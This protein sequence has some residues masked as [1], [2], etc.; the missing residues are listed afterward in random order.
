[1]ILSDLAIFTEGKMQVFFIIFCHELLISSRNLGRIFANFLF[2]LISVA[3]F[4]LLA[5]GQETQGSTTFYSI[6]IIWFSL[7]SV[8]I[9]SATDFLK[10]DFEDGSI[11]QILNSCDNFEVFI[12]AKMLANWLVNSLPIIITILPIGYLI[13]L[14]SS[15]S[16]NLFL[17][18]FL[19]SLVINFICS[20]CGS[21]SILGNSAPMIA[22]IALPLIVPVILLAC[23]GFS[24]D[25]AASAKILF[26]MCF[27]IGAI[28]V[29]AAAKIVKI[30][31]D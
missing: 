26:G 4:L 12:C 20:F 11:E 14:D 1:M 7:L 2:F 19:A 16:Y 25:F 28:S 22:V 10:K 3:I 21:L 15:Q 23:G 13:N 27:F 29:F 17:L 24:A 9:F 8:L 18:A 31:A 30:A 5:Q 6:T